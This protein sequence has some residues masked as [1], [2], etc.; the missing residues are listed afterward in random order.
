[1]TVRFL[2]LLV[3]CLLWSG[4]VEAQNRLD[5]LDRRGDFLGWEAVGRVDKPDGFCTGTL[6]ASDTV[7]TAAHC[8]FD[9]AG[10]LLPPDQLLF[11][12]GYA[13]GASVAERRGSRLVV[14]PGYQHSVNGI[15]DPNQVNRDIALIQLDRPISAAEADPFRIHEAPRAGEPVSVVSY[16]AGREDNLS[17]EAECNVTGQYQ[18][19]IMSF[20]C[21]V[22][23]G[24][25][26]APVFARYGTRPRILS[27]IS[28]GRDLGQDGVVSFGAELPSVVTALQQELRNG[29]V[30]A[31]SASGAKRITVGQRTSGG[32]KFIRP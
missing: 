12:A 20:D 8:L 18:G 1:M 23:F 13:H 16:G 2:N 4:A 5:S 9:H 30:V 32:A 26:G 27:L 15:M 22:T 31:P 11:R 14:A 25:S 17:R 3:L 24:S 7:L 29:S 19:G 21:N 28:G 10:R 6:I